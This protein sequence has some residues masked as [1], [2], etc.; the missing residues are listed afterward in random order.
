M[1]DELIQGIES[2]DGIKDAR[3]ILDL[4]LSSSDDMRVLIDQEPP[5]HFTML[6]QNPVSAVWG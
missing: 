5:R 4:D 1:I 2:Q 3:G 6:A